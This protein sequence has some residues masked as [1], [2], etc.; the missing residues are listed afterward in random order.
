MSAGRTV[1]VH[2][3][4]YGPVT[5]V[6]PPWCLTVHVD[7]GYRADICHAGP[8]TALA[9]RGE[10]LWHAET[11][12][13]PYAERLPRGIG[14]YVAQTDYAGTFDPDGLDGLA[15][16]FVEHAAALRHLA[17]ELAALHAGNGGAR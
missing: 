5:F 9:F 8:A 3:V 4:D 12:A 15:E 1:T 11:V 10:Q 6:C 2:S 7:G 17:R 16:A 14:V 13:Y